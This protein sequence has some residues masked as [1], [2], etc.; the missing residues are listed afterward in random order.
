MLT[1]TIPACDVYNEQ[2]G[3]FLT[4]DHPVTLQL[5]HS[6]VSLTKWEEKWKK[7]FLD[8]YTERSREE[9]NDYVRCMTITKNVDPIVY[10]VIPD[11]VMKKIN[12]Y[13]DDPMTATTFR[14]RP[15]QVQA[16]SF[17]SRVSAE[18]IY[19]WMF[20]YGI[21]KECEK[22]HL[23]KL[24]TLIRVFN[25]KNNSSK[26]KRSTLNSEEMQNRSMI[27]AQRRAALGTKG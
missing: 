27:N 11:S 26:N 4:L 5:E 3:E 19:Y 2:T 23:N 17:N 9:S 22:W 24:L 20:S 10:S 18:V 1:V 15:G 14:E 12:D 7:R 8:K 16:G 21:P 25:D 13:V 6:L